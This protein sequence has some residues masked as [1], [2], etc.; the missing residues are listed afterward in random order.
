MGQLENKNKSMLKAAFS[1]LEHGNSETLRMLMA[2]D[3]C[4]EV[5]GSTSWSQKFRGK[6]T[7][8][9]DL[10]SVLAGNFATQYSNTASRIFADD[11]YVIVECKGK[12]KTIQGADYN[13]EYCWICE[14]SDE[15]LVAVTEYGDTA[16]IEKV[17][18]TYS[19]P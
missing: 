13:N 2:E 18:P 3:I 9:N 8:L 19:K 14:F 6:A 4:W 5:K 15:K 7:V 11:N 17:L 1:Q 10:F 16:L 12:V